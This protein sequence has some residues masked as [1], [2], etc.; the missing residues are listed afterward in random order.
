MMNLKTIS[1]VALAAVAAGCFA[2]QVHAEEASTIGDAMTRALF[3]QSGDIY[4]NRN[5]DRQATLLFGLSFPEHEY[6][7]DAQAVERIYKDGIR[8]R[9]STPINT[10]DLPNPF[11]SSLLSNPGA[12]GN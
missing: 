10:P 4:R 8:Q 9:T 6:F 7:N 11:T 1:L 12:T 5:I 3:N 2:P